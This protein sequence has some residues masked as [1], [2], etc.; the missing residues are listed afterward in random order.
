VVAGSALSDRFLAASSTRS[1]KPARTGNSHEN[2]ACQ[3]S[4][5]GQKHHQ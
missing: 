1:E 5:K 2:D 3:R 4:V